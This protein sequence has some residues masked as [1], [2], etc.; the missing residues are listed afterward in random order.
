MVIIGFSGKMGSGKNYIAEQIVAKFLS[1]N[2]IPYL[3]IAFADQLKI[4]V[5]TKYNLSYDELFAFKSPETRKILQE[6][7]TELGRNKKGADI[8][9]KYVANWIR[10]FQAR[11]ITHFL[12]PDVRFINEATWIKEQPNSYLIK[13][14]AIDRHQ[15]YIGDKHF[16][17]SNHQSEIQL[18][19]WKD[20]DFTI[21]NTIENEKNV[22]IQ[23]IEYLINSSISTTK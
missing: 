4:E 23:T 8:W 6:E 16:N 2:N 15:L 10:I 11:G 1:Q 13:I 19:E 20:W 5:M 14:D 18:D 12:I 3:V 21:N 9:I 17:M 22:E 7:G